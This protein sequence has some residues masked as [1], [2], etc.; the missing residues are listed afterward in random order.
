MKCHLRFIAA[1]LLCYAFPVTSP[2][3]QNVPVDITLDRDGILL[4]G[5]F[6]K[7]DCE[8]LC[9]ALLLLPGMPGNETDVIGLGK[10]LAPTGVHV[11]MI[12]FSGT[13]QSQGLWGY[14]NAQADIAAAREFLYD[15]ANA[16]RFGID[17]ASIFLGGYSYGGGMAMTY[18]IKHPEIK[19]IISIAGN[20]WGEHFEDYVH[21]PGLKAAIDGIV[22]RAVSSGI[23]RPGTGER[24]EELLENGTGNLDPA[25]Y[26]KENAEVL[27]RKEILL[28][29]GWDDAGVSIDRYVL[30]LYRALQKENAQDISMVAF[31]DDHSFRNSRDQIARVIRDWIGQIQTSDE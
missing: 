5:K 22:E 14:M 27:A 13:H 6:Y 21:N 11:M 9:P 29:S 17:T 2:A 24:P 10:R 4:K 3:Q 16:D 30:P 23:V 15:P 28:I 18:A 1:I 20:D 26:L 8:G 31:Q 19:R 12:N 25:L 7:A